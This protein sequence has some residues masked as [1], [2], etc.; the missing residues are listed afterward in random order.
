MGHN[1]VTGQQQWQKLT[2]HHKAIILQLNFFFFKCAEN[3]SY[4]PMDVWLTHLVVLYLFWIL[5]S[6]STEARIE[7]DSK[8]QAALSNGHSGSNYFKVICA[9]G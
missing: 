4:I 1:L 7:V 8:H 6:A 5:L 3:K 9:H 2:H